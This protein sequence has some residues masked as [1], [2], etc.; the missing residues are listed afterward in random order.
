MF[1]KPYPFEYLGLR[2]TLMPNPVQK[3]LYR[4]N[5]EKRRYLVTFEV[6]SF[7]VVAVKYC[8]LK[9]QN[10]ANRFERIYNDND[11]FRV[12]TTCLYVMLDY[13]RRHNDVTFAFYAVPRKFDDTVMREKNLTGRKLKNFTER[14]KKVRFAIY[15]Y[16]MLNLF[17]PSAFILLR[18]SENAVYLLMNKK[19]NRPK[20]IITEF[21]MFLFDN[22]EMIFDPAD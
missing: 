7:G 13:W 22:Y 16:A 18:D 15:D 4:F 6:Y 1:D 12:I 8:G 10:A 2:E 5:G 14:F 21:S 9:D 20:T 11:A 19:E 17:P 3:V